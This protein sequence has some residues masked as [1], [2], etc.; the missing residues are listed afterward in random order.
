MNFFTQ[1]LYHRTQSDDEDIADIASEEWEL[2]NERYEEHLRALAPQMPPGVCELNALLLHDA[3]LQELAQQDD[4]LLMV[5]HKDI[6][7]RDV[8]LLTY[9]LVAQ[10]AFEPFAPVP[11]VW[12]QPTLFQFDEISATQQDAATIWEQAIVFANGW[13]L[14][15]RFRDVRVELARPLEFP[16]EGVRALAAT[17]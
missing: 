10:P 7:P 2:T 16:G 3:R 9:D 6:P 8:V 1:A 5:L 13:L 12:S 4:R 17:A 14:R 11:R 15:L